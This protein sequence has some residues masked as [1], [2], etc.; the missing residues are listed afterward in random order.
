MTVKALKKQLMA[1]IAMVVVSA[2]ALSSS[3]YAWFA[4]NNVVTATNM[5][6]TAKTS[7]S[8]VI[9]NS[10]L[11]VASTGTITVA[12]SDTAA[13]AVIPTTHDFTTATTTGLKYNTNPGAVSAST[14][15]KE[16][17]EEL[18]F[19]EAVTEGQTV[20]YLD[21]TV[22]IA[23]SGSALAGQDIT[24]ELIQD[25]ADTT[26]MGAT[27]VDF[28]AATVNTATP[29]TINETNFV[30]TLNLAQKDAVENDSTTAKTSQ[31]ISN[32]T[33]PQSGE[34]SAIAVTMRVYVDGALKDSD[35]TTFVKNVSVANISEVNL[36]VQFTA[37]AHTS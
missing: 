8:L 13:T 25:A 12:A 37:G 10:Q 2:I 27:S 30:G 24:I 14:G 29:V 6:V 4:S 17:T 32:V 15:L 11:P 36:G 5:Q 28:Y 21:Y 3:T 1:A 7:G 9:T 35:T 19:A 20:Y 16:A 23:A 31:T 26:L 34:G 22:Y 18:T 33:I